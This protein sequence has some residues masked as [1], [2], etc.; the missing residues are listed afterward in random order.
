MTHRDVDVLRAR[1]TAIVGAATMLGRHA[2]DLHCLG[3]ERAV[4]DEAKVSKTGVVEVDAIGDPLI[5][6]LWRRLFEEIRVIETTIRAL[7]WASNN[8]LSAGAG[9]EESRGSL[10]SKGEFNAALRRQRQRGDRGEYVPAK[11]VDQPRYPGSTTA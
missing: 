2:E 11:L 6:Q 7:E 8:A 3:F 4:R 10:V 9:V 5:R 1:L